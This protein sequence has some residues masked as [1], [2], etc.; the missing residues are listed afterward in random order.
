MWRQRL[1]ALGYLSI[2]I[3]PLTLVAGVMLG[4]PSLAA[5][6]A[7]LA[8]PLAR[9]VFGVYRK[10]PVWRESIASALHLLPTAYA[11]TLLASLAAL[12]ILIDNA[13]I[14]GI[15]AWSGLA[16]SLALTLLFATC[17]GHEL[18]HR[19]EAIDLRIGAWL[20]GI[21][22]YPLLCV[23]HRDHH[24]NQA[25]TGLAAEPRCDESVWRFSWCR[26]KAVARFAFELWKGKPSQAQA[27]IA[28]R[29]L[30]EAC[31]LTLLTVI[32]FTVCGGLPGLAAYAASC[33]IVTF[34]IQVMTFIQHWGL[35]SNA[36]H[37]QQIAWED[38]CLF[39]AWVTLHTSFH[40]SH[41]RK[42]NLPFYRLA[43]APDAPRLPAGYI[44]LL[45]ASLVPRLWRAAM[46]PALTH[47]QLQPSKPP[48]PGRR[49]SCFNAYGS[50]NS[51]SSAEDET[52]R[53]VP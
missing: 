29:N 36:G 18:L 31:C 53:Q 12:L 11:L 30:R 16:V 45:F 35:S 50:A 6:V 2:L 17:S 22:G 44:V 1:A 4:K 26:S 40:Q 51:A 23:E 7:L 15:A 32:L 47:W 34:G 3:L 38:D 27:A 52:D 21:T 28:R 46:Q 19:R 33:V 14:E 5:G 9:A 48:S 49:F 25:A 37:Y 8:F 42:P 24:L 43:L 13:A 39:Q 20:A 10:P 41:H